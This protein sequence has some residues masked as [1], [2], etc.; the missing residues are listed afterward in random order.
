MPY[1]KTTSV[2]APFGFT[3]P[4]KTAELKV[5]ELAEHVLTVGAMG[6]D[7]IYS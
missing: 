7:E 2:E 5:T 3:V 6:M 4:F 1:S